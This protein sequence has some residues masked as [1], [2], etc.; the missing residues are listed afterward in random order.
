MELYSAEGIA[1][2]LKANADLDDLI[3]KAKRIKGCQGVRLSRQP[4]WGLCHIAGM[5]GIVG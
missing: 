2:M 1:V 4:L 5:T 3:E